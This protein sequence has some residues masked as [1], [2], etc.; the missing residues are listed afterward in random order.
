MTGFIGTVIGMSQAVGS[1]D[2]VLSNADNVD[3][4]KDGLVQVT[5]GL[6]TA[7]DTTF[8]ALVFLFFS[9]SAHPLRKK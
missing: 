4:L 7:F 9:L 6:G 1:F 8:L 5:G 3:G 2:A